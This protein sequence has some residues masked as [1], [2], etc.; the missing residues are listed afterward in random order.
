MEDFEIIATSSKTFG[1]SGDYLFLRTL[2]LL[3]RQHRTV[4]R[5]TTG[6]FYLPRFALKTLKYIGYSRAFVH[7]MTAKFLP[8]LLTRFMGW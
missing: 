8:V 1:A 2:L 6:Y 4:H 5:G 7:T 3:P